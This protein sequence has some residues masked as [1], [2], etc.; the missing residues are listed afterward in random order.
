MGCSDRWHMRTYV[1][2][3]RTSLRDQRSGLV[4]SYRAAMSAEYVVPVAGAL[5]KAALRRLYCCTR[6]RARSPWAD[7]AGQ[8]RV[9]FST[10]DVL[11]PSV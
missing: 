1:P 8:H 5:V 3:L 6:C 11:N 7:A 4:Q 9:L 2:V 10:H